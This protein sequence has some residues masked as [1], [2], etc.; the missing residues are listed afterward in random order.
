MRCCVA[1]LPYTAYYTMD[2]VAFIRVSVPVIHTN[3]HTIVRLYCAVNGLS[4][5]TFYIYSM[6]CISTY[7]YRQ[8]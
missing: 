3:S 1:L 8:F 6:Q 4:E 7:L 5:H 2:D